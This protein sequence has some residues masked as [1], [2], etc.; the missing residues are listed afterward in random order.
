MPP[1]H[2]LQEIIALHF[3]K[4]WGTPYW[5][6]QALDISPNEIMSVEDLKRFPPFPKDVLSQRPVTDFVPKRFHTQLNNFISCETGGT[7]GPPSRTVFRAD[8]F[9]AAFVAPFLAAA[10]VM[11][12]P[13]D[14]N[15][16]FV[17]PS[18]PH[19]IGKAARL[20]AVEMGSIDPFT[21]DFDP[22]WARKLA[23]GLGL[24]RYT[25]HVADQAMAILATQ[26]VG[27]IFATPPMLA[28]LGDQLPCE[29]RE[30]IGGI[31]TG[32]MAA[33]QAFWTRLSGEW[34]PNAVVI[35]GY[36]NSLA[37]MCP[38]LQ[39]LSSEPPSYFSHGHRLVVGVLENGHVYFHRLDESCFLPFVIERDIA[40]LATVP[41][42]AAAHGF[43]HSGL[44]DPR[45][46]ASD[47]A[48]AGL[49]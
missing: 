3:D 22:R 25:E 23:G 32:G 48:K 6:T 15:W 38:Q 46:P 7:T 12:F 47:S 1:E 19:P 28:T 41:A 27:V 8:E 40:S 2:R 21:V 10:E 16:L 26:E 4:R 34:F 30:C 36:G 13:R 39:H 9:H 42:T 29:I 31:H 45:P 44:R 43:L 18:G 37:G 24:K 14:R 33:D 49:Y 35:S 5:L 20:C 11:A 17:G